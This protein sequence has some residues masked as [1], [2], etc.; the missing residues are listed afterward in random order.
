MGFT[1][2]SNHKQP[3]PPCVCEHTQE[4][5]GK[6]AVCTHSVTDNAGTQTLPRPVLTS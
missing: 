1:L 2:F 5:E 3:P 6:P 4:Y